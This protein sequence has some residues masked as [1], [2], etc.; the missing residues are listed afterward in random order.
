MG[1]SI[2]EFRGNK[3]H[4]VRYAVQVCW[5]GQTYRFWH[6]PDGAGD[7]IYERYIAEKLLDKVQSD[8]DQHNRRNGRGFTFK[9]ETYK[10]KSTLA[11]GKYSQVW[12]K[13]LTVRK[14]TKKGYKAATKHAISHFGENFDIRNLSL[15]KLKEFYN[16]LPF[17]QKT[18]YNVLTAIKT[19][20]KFA[21]AD[22]QLD[23]LPAFPVLKQPKPLDTP[24]LTYEMQ[25]EILKHIPERHRPIFEMGMAYGFRVE[26][27]RALKWDCVSDEHI[28]IRRT[29][30]EYELI[31]T[32]KEEVSRVEAITTRARDI[33]RRARLNLSWKGF[34]FTASKRGAPYDY[35]FMSRTW[36]SACDG[37]GIHIKMYQGFRHSYCS[38]LA[39][40]GLTID[41]IQRQVGHADRRST[42]R[43]TR[44]QLA[45]ERKA[46]NEM[47]GQVV[48][49][50]KKVEGE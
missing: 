26:E 21:Y 31:E 18:K 20:L 43:Y 44:R 19:M 30:P 48:K 41:Q 15:S 37:A 50:E 25:R 49:F 35:K 34:V 28:T 33:L 5:E 2:L 47:L 45:S 1:G 46:I 38:Q 11:L 42:E 10:K 14:M 6:Y 17:A 24:Y 8:I 29:M 16:A 39:D 12:L 32:T 22:G 13:S 3:R 36:K 23:R 9:P 27:V 40:L 7:P 4:P